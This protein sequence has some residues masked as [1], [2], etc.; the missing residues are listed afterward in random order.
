MRVC[1]GEGVHVCGWEIVT[2]STHDYSYTLEYE[3]GEGV[4]MV[5]VH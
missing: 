5:R 3:K 4:M 2:W 1:S